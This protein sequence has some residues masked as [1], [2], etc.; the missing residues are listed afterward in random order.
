MSSPQVVN[1]IPEG[2]DPGGLRR[3]MRVPV[4]DRG[5]VVLMVGVGGKE[6]DYGEADVRQLTL[7]MRE[8]WGVLGAQESRKAAAHNPG[9]AGVSRGQFA[10]GG[11]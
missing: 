3:W 5:R 9:S 11:H 10:P 1:E 8:T 6:R 4:T 7:L 2:E